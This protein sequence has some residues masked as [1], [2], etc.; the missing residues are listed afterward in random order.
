MRKYPLKKDR[1]YRIF[2]KS[3]AGFEVLRSAK[4]SQHQK[5]PAKFSTYLS[6]KEKDSLVI[7][8]ISILK[9]KERVLYG[10]ADSKVF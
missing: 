1:I 6:L 8:D 3:I 4:E 10:R 5:P 2:T 7:P 9:A